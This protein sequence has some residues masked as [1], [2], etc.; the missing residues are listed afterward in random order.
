[1]G[2]PLIRTRVKETYHLSRKRIKRG[3]VRAFADIT[4]KTGARQVFFLRYTAMPQWYN[5]ID[6]VRN[7]HP[8][9]W[10]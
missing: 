9:R 1:M 6:M 10:Q 7:A 5:V 2:G 4:I 8:S 3:N